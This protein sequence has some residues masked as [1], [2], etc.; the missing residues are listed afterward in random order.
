MRWPWPIAGPGVLWLQLDRL[1]F[2]DKPAG[3]PAEERGHDVEHGVIEAADVQDVA[4][5]RG[6][7]RVV[8]LAATK[9]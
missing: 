8:R 9:C 3:V 5:V 1:D 7:R 6:L 2:G 4:A